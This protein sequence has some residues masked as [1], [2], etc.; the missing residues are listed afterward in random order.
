M[1]KQLKP[2]F[3]SY[4]HLLVAVKQARHACK[5]EEPGAEQWVFCDEY[6]ER[7]W[8]LVRDYWCANCYQ[9]RHL[10]PFSVSFVIRTWTTVR[11]TG[12]KGQ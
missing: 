6:R 12:E 1:S 5:E 9:P 2:E 7:A 3:V 8:K 4:D 11:K 10:F